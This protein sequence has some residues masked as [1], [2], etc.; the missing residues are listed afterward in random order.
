ML[1]R[2][3]GAESKKWTKVIENT[4]VWLIRPIL[5]MVALALALMICIFIFTLVTMVKGN[6]LSAKVEDAAISAQSLSPAFTQ[7][8]T[9]MSLF[10]NLTES[11]AVTAEEFS[12]GFFVDPIAPPNYAILYNEGLPNQTRMAYRMNGPCQ[13]SDSTAIVIIHDLGFSGVLWI[14]QVNSLA[15]LPQKYC[16]MAID[17]LGHGDSD[18]PLTGGAY[19]AQAGYLH[20]FMTEVRLLENPARGLFLMGHGFGAAIAMQYTADF[21]GVVDGF[22]LE[23]P[24]PYA[25]DP[26]DPDGERT[27]ETGALSESN[28]TS[29][30]NL[31]LSNMP[32]YA[33]ATASGLLVGS[34]CSSTVLHPMSAAF[35][36]LLFKAIPETLSEG[37]V[38]L[39]TLDHRHLFETNTSPILM[40]TGTTSG[41]EDVTTLNF[42][43]LAQTARNLASRTADLHV[44]GSAAGAPHLTN[45][46]VFTSLVADFLTGRPRLCDAASINWAQI[47]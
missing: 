24:L 40:I 20:R 23:N 34:A 22:I 17:L 33:Q 9:Y 4:P 47:E 37:M 45:H 43:K 32:I 30:A 15:A 2:D 35:M 38:S 5:I 42:A 26:D 1:D 3:L 28:M 39:M 6:A 13:D 8:L 41:Y 19:V 21:P 27:A 36:G 44:L 12:E 7:L 29:A 25:V 16:A 18:E 14:E 11:G 10:A 46:A 31:M